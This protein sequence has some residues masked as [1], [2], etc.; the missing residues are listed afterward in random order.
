MNKAKKVLGNK[1]HI[2]ATGPRPAEPV[3]KIHQA[4][5]VAAILLITC[6]VF[7]PSLGNDF[8][9]SWDDGLNIRDNHLT[10][11]FDF[12]TVK[13]I[14][15]A[16]VGQSYIPLVI[17][18]FA[19]ERSKAGLHP[20]LY[21][22]DN[23]LLHLV[24]IV[25]VYYLIRIL[26]KK[27]WMPA[28]IALLFGIHP[29][30]VE[31]V[32]WI[33][34][35]KDVL[36]GMFYL[37]S[38]ICY[39]KMIQSGKKKILFYF[40]SLGLFVLSLLSKIQAVSLPLAMF[41]IDYLLKRK[42]NFK[43]IAE[44][45]PFLVLS[46]AIGVAGILL[47]S[48][49][50]SLDFNEKY[51]MLNRIFLGFFAYCVYIVKSIVPYELSALY[52]YPKAINGALPWLYYASV[53]PVI[54]ILVFVIMRF[55]KSGEVIFGIL[56][57][58]VNI[59]F[60]L[61]ILGAGKAFMADRFSYIS[62]LGLFFIFGDTLCKKMKSKFLQTVTIT[63]SVIVLVTFCSVSYAR[64]SVWRNSE[65]LWTDVIKKYPE[66]ATP[67]NN[68]GI[69]YRETGHNDLAFADYS[70]VISINPGYFIA[71]VS[72]GNI[73]FDNKQYDLALDD[74]NKADAGGIKSEH[75][76][77]NRGAVLSMKGEYQK[78]LDDFEH[79]LKINPYHPNAF[80]S[81]AICYMYMKKFDMALDDFKK[82]LQLAPGDDDTFNSIAVCYQYIDQADES[83]IWFGKAISIKPLG[84]YFYNRSIS[85]MK[86]GDKSNAMKDAME[87]KRLG[88]AIS[89][90]YLQTLK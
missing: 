73:Y 5:A 44:K 21:H 16:S 10:A 75:L 3:K 28:F 79:S 15:T 89:D 34:E 57:F 66:E 77:A 40:F 6:I 81:R 71:Y 86:K 45:L 50:D 49:G 11:K 7:S 8:V 74:Y 26:T 32:V 52:S 43:L 29:M 64:C 30:H 22:F 24:C 46:I 9:N 62:Y 83:L 80:K 36:Y 87:A 39:V 31:S 42:F 20:W 19:W 76:F 37:G 67:Y 48:S 72:R 2:S 63:L 12:I 4:A 55:R 56:F 54:A 69:Y 35:R 53:I 68:R 78:A 23:L 47:L 38:L 1:K 85:Y 88:A 14:F 90:A 61:Q 58:T 82:Y 27:F 33:T 41:A 65:T 60:L 25:L 59:F 13:S 17:T 51:S 84:A 70:K 18:S